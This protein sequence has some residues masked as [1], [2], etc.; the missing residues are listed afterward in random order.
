VL[1]GEL[2][3]YQAFQE[4]RYIGGDYMDVFLIVAKYTPRT[5]IPDLS[6]GESVRPCEGMLH[7]DGMTMDGCV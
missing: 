1:R 2:G 5:S 3:V 6:G 4:R 7:V